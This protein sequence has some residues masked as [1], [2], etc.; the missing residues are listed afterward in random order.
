MR[1][2][3]MEYIKEIKIKSKGNWL[4]VS[5]YVVPYRKRHMRRDLSRFNGIFKVII[6]CDTY[7]KEVDMTYLVD[8]EVLGCFSES[9]ILPSEKFMCLFMLCWT[10]EEMI[11]HDNSRMLLYDEIRI[12][13]E[14]CSELKDY[15]SETDRFGFKYK[16]RGSE[17]DSNV[18][19]EYCYS[20]EGDIFEGVNINDMAGLSSRLSY[21]IVRH[22]LPFWELTNNLMP[23]WRYVLE[24]GKY[25]LNGVYLMIPLPTCKVFKI[26]ERCRT[27]IAKYALIDGR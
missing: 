1:G 20:E 5:G 19:A 9:A 2:S 21:Y 7:E 16:F 24:F 11:L 10:K 26:N 4:C 3:F 8:N 25:R 22:N 23:V 18:F 15:I 12:D 14:L 17:N 27:I 13:D 6:G